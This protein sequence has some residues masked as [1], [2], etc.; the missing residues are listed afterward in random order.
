MFCL[1]IKEENAV[2]PPRTCRSPAVT[3]DGGAASRM[4]TA[5]GARPA[6]GSACLVLPQ[7]IGAAS[8]MVWTRKTSERE[9]NNFEATV[10]VM[11]DFHTRANIAAPGGTTSVLPSLSSPGKSGTTP[12]ALVVAVCHGA[13]RAVSICELAH[14]C[15]DQHIS[16]QHGVRTWTWTW[17]PVSS[18]AGQE[19]QQLRLVARREALDDGL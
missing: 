5:D 10:V 18:V 8:Q 17:G 6:A 9:N 19:R 1:E 4:A 11:L 16:E 3:S 12:S 2:F 7:P 14:N 15:K 13:A